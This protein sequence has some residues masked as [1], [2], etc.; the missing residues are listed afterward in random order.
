MFK[1]TLRQLEYFQSLSKTL[2]FS[3]SADDCY[4]GQ[5]TLSSSIKD[6]EHGIGF[7]LFERTSRRV[8]LT[9]EGEQLLKSVKDLLYKQ[10]TLL[11]HIKT[12]ENPNEHTIRL[13]IIPTIAPFVLPKL[14]QS[15]YNLLFREGLSSELLEDL[16]EK[17]IDVA[18]IALPYPLKTH[19]KTHFLFDDPLYLA[20][21]IE[22][23]TPDEELPFIFLEDGHCLRDQAISVCH[24]NLDSISS[25]FQGTSLNSVLSLV[26]NS[27]GQTF[28]PKMS[29]PFFHHLE[30]VEFV[31]PNIGHA[32]RAIA[33]AWT[34]PKNK[35]KA[36]LLSSIFENK[37]E[38]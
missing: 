22:N 38:I 1:P 30:N 24:V 13:G 19:V 16:E 12:L 25:Q 15:E 10:E 27:A 6:L 31:A 26:Q 5:S 37:N 2:S 32:A 33:L 3:Q 35:D 18:L 36:L 23:A 11:D 28:V 34:S 20:K 21:P 14:L 9:A 7:A 29:L 8:F 4:V 17:R